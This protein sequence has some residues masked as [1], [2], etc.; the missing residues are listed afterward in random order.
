M[1]ENRN[2][3]LHSSDHRWLVGKRQ[4]WDNTISQFFTIYDPEDWQESDR[5]FF[6]NQETVLNYPDPGKCQW[7]ESVR[8]AKKRKLGL[9][10]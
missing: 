5:K 9:D 1:W 7:I 2:K 6:K 4:E 8:K 3:T 10:N